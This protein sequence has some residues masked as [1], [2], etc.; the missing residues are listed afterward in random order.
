MALKRTSF[1]RKTHERAPLAAPR[2]IRQVAATRISDEVQAVP[3][4]PRYADRHLL[5]MARG[6]PCLLRSP[7]CNNDIDTSVACHGAGVALGK[8][9]AYKISDPLSVIGCSSCNNYTDAY[10]GATAIEKRA[11]FEAGHARQVLKWKRVAIS[12]TAPARDKAS[13]QA[14]LDYLGTIGMTL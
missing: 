7:I 2:P 8:G 9:L 14:A 10:G 13:A 12:L 11:V 1:K 6:Q 3:K 5:D 4:H